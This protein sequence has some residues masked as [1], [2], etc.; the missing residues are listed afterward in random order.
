L[1]A[2]A[3][4]NDI[5]SEHRH[6]ANPFTLA[7]CRRHFV[8]CALAVSVRNAC[9]SFRRFGFGSSMSPRY[10]RCSMMTSVKS[11]ATC[12]RCSARI[13]PGLMP[14]N[15]ARWSMTRSRRSSAVRTRSLAV[16]APKSS[17]FHITGSDDSSASAASLRIFDVGQCPASAATAID[18]IAFPSACDRFY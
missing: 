16:P 7:A 4:G 18:L 10:N 6:S 1:S 9:L 3:A 2:T 15:M 11:V 13:S 14:S 12:V 5:V 17:G 8:A